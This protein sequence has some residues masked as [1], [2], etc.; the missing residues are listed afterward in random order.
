MSIK[1][2]EFTFTTTWK[3]ICC[4]I[5]AICYVVLKVNGELGIGPFAKEKRRG[6]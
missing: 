4:T 1:F 2:D 5:A 6:D 3:I